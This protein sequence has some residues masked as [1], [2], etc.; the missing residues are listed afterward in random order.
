MFLD[1]LIRAARAQG[2]L[3]LTEELDKLFEW[4]VQG[5]AFNPGDVLGTNWDVEG[6][7]REVEN[8]IRIEARGGWC[9]NP[10]DDELVKIDTRAFE[11]V[12]AEHVRMVMR[13]K[14]IQLVWFWNID[15]VRSPYY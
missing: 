12:I 2:F 1:E 3:E 10:Y 8:L 15:L 7:E 14:R 9:P 13:G 6:V 4:R 5:K 11:R